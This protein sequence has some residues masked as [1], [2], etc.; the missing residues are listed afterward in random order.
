MV[1][2]VIYIPAPK[3]VHSPPTLS[4]HILT[5]QKECVKGCAVNIPLVGIYHY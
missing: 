5:N 3:K 4:N 1:N 2:L